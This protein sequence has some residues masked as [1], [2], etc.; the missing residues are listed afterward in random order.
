MAINLFAVQLLN[1]FYSEDKRL[2]LTGCYSISFQL[3]LDIRD[4]QALSLR[5]KKTGVFILFYTRCLQSP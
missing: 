4:D 5:E 1:A 3:L 2:N